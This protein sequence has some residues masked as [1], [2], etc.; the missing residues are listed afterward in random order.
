MVGANDFVAPFTQV[1]GNPKATNQ[2]A[3]VGKALRTNMAS[4]IGRIHELAP[5]TRVVVLGYWN[6]M[7]DGQAAAHDYTAAQRAASLLATDTANEALRSAAVSADAQFVPT[8]ELFHGKS[9]NRDPST[10]LAADGDHPN[11]AGHQAIA[12]ALAA[13][14]PAEPQTD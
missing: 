3:T 7:E 12:A 14:V 11:V 9:K 13:A 8:L 4:I 5:A 6:V 1:T 10:M 2:F